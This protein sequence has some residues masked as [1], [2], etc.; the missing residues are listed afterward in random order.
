MVGTIKQE[1]ERLSLKVI[2]GM[3][4]NDEYDRGFKVGGEVWTKFG[5][6]AGAKDVLGE[7]EMIIK[8]EDWKLRGEQLSAKILQRI[9]EL[10][11]K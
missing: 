6:E 7:I 4:E 9:K 11:K 3:G 1:A 2:S 8:S 10:K 5:Y